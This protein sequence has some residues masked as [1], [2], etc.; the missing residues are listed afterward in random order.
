LRDVLEFIGHGNEQ[1]R[2]V[3]FVGSDLRLDDDGWGS[4]ARI[5]GSVDS[6]SIY[7]SNFAQ[8][9]YFYISSGQMTVAQ[10]LKTLSE[11]RAA[12]GL[13]VE[14][15]TD[16]CRAY[17]DAGLVLPP[18]TIL[19]D[20]YHVPIFSTMRRCADKFALEFTGIT[21]DQSEAFKNDEDIFHELQNFIGKALEGHETARV[22]CTLSGGADSAALLSVVRLV[23]QPSRIRTLTCR[24]PGFE[25]ELDRAKRISERCGV[26][27][28][29][30]YPDTI[31]AEGVLDKYTDQFRN[32][33]YDPVVPVLA[34]M[35]Q[36]YAEHLQADG[37]K[38]F[39]IEGQGADTVLTGLP[40]NAARRRRRLFGC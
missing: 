21:P 24:M 14:I 2:S 15:N 8:P 35:F 32:L 13:A 34:S 25:G 26:E 7:F 30:Y 6:R 20:V 40:H 31:D 10:S 27:N 36:S 38:T 39:V 12:L 29:V 28:Q 22:L 5:A 17:Q 23:A 11:R 18:F 1:I 16:L 19:R 37:E 33:V 3:V 4:I 9:F